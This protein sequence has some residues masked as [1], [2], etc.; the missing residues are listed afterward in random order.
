MQLP[1]DVVVTAAAAAAAVHSAG[2]SATL[3]QAAFTEEQSLG[4][5]LAGAAAVAPLRGS[6]AWTPAQMQHL[7]CA[8]RQLARCDDALRRLEAGGVFAG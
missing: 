6:L 2:A 8:F 7:I 1:P 5:V 3:L 4:E